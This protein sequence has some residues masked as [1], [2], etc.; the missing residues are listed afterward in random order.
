MLRTISGLQGVSVLS[1]ADQKRIAGGVAASC[2]NVITQTDGSRCVHGGINKATA[3]QN[4]AD[5]NLGQ[6]EMG[7][8]G[9]GSVTDVNWCCASCGTFESC[10]DMIDA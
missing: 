1:R 7:S 10:G 9:Y 5:Y 8:G 3:V 6:G 4:S 2:G